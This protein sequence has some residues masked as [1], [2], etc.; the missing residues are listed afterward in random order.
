MD[1]YS[2]I[3]THDSADKSQN[4]VLSKEILRKEYILYFSIDMKF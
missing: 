3:E 2:T 4:I 1:H